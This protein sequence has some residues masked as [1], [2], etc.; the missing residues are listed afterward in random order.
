MRASRGSRGAAVSQGLEVFDLMGGEV[1]GAG[2]G[3]R[4]CRAGARDARCCGGR[5]VAELR[6]CKGEVGAGGGGRVER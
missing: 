6:S 1:P 3:R 2:I 5:C 4:G